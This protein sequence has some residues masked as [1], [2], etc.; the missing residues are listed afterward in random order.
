MVPASF[1]ESNCVLGRPAEL[2][3]DECTCLSVLMTETVSGT[4]VVISCHKLTTG[5]LEEIQR[6]GRVWLTVIGQ[7]M[8]PVVLNGIKPFYINP[9]LAAG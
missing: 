1:E 7:G 5:E 3:D 2:N 9:P 8:P 6:T 4:P